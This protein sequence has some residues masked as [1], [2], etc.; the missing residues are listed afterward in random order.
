MINPDKELE[1][2]I[3]ALSAK[4]DRMWVAGVLVGFLMVVVLYVSLGR[5]L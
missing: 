2:R 4:L 5:L 1:E 3:D